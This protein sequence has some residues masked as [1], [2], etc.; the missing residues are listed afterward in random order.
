MNF[1]VLFQDTSSLILWKDLGLPLKNSNINKKKDKQTR[2]KQ[3]VQVLLSPHFPASNLLFSLYLLFGKWHHR[4]LRNLGFILNSLSP[5][6]PASNIICLFSFSSFTRPCLWSGLSSLAWITAILESPSPLQSNLH[7]ATVVK[8]PWLS[9]HR[10]RT[11]IR[12]LRFWRIR[13]WRLYS[14]AMQ[15]KDRAG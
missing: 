7:M 1:T 8:K 4:L 12:R 14:S 10:C 15:R 5:S 9:V 11:E 2:N 3:E 6:F 13:L